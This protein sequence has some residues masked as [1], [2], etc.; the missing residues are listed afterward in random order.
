MMFRDAVVRWI[1]LVQIH[2]GRHREKTPLD[3]PQ[4]PRKLVGPIDFRIGTFLQSPAKQT[5]HCKYCAAHASINQTSPAR[6]LSQ[7]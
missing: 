1:C 3:V 2:D 6:L 5:F 7:R 4:R